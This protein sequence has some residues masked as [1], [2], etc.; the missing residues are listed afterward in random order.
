MITFS[1]FRRCLRQQIRDPFTLS[2]TF[3]TTPLMIIFYW[4]FIT[5]ANT[6]EIIIIQ[7]GQPTAHSKNLVSNLIEQIPMIAP[8]LK[9]M[10]SKEADE[11]LSCKNSLKTIVSIENQPDHPEKSIFV[12]IFG[13]NQ[14][15]YELYA[16]KIKSVLDDLQIKNSKIQSSIFINLEKNNSLKNID[17]FTIFVPGFIVFSIIMIIFSTSMMITSEIESGIF[18]RYKLSNT[19]ILSFLMGISILQILNGILSVTISLTVAYILGFDSHGKI[20]EICF[21]CFLGI[22][23]NISIG[24]LLSSFTKTTY[25]SFLFS[26]FIM[27]LLLIVSGIIFPKPKELTYFNQW[28][29]MNPFQFIPTALVKE[30]LDFVIFESK[31]LTNLYSNIITLF[32]FTIVFI[33]FSY[34]SFKKLLFTPKLKGDSF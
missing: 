32:V 6:P 23:A 31:T 33:F 26:S 10:Q 29:E 2:L 22:L 24:L 13:C 15:E 17:D 7:K 20:F 9:I 25:Q 18:I 28:I 8:E 14:K 5:N 19:P 11:S 27:F 3:F 12:N 30:S 1:I 4:L 16:Y 34:L 21:F